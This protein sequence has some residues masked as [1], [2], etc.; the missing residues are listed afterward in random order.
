M[1]DLSRADALNRQFGIPGLARLIS[2]NGGLSKLVVNAKSASAEIYLHGAQVTSW[3]PVGAEEVIF[4]SGHSHWEDGHAIRGGIPVSFPWFRAKADDPKAPAHG[5]VRTREWQL[6]S[7]IAKEDGSVI[8]VFSTEGDASTRR[9]W[10][11]E[12]RL[13]L[14]ITIGSTL[15]LEL[16]ATNKG[17]APFSFEE[18]LHTYFR[19]GQAASVRVRGLNGVSYLDNVDQNREKTQSGDLVLTGTTDN[20]YLSIQSAAELVDP[21]LC[22]TVRTEKGNSRTTVVWNPWQRGAASLSD[23]G[24][25]EWQQMTCVEASNILSCAVQLGPGEDHTMRANLC[26]APE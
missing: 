14:R 7:V 11:H 26:V 8:A 2:G 23:L 24:E 19:V 9:W 10:P 12:F 3:Q 5:F 20:A 22:R 18:A 13:A 25:D 6:D 4:L 17:S 21:V 1:A 15:G 16:T